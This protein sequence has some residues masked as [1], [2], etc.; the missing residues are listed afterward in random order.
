M[1]WVFRTLVILLCFQGE[2][3]ADTPWFSFAGGCWRRVDSIDVNRLNSNVKMEDVSFPRPLATND[4][5]GKSAAEVKKECLEARR[6]ALDYATD[7]AAKCCLPVEVAYGTGP[8][9]SQTDPEDGVDDAH[10]I[11]QWAKFAFTVDG[12]RSSSHFLCANLPKAQTPP[13][14]TRKFVKLTVVCYDGKI[15]CD[16]QSKFGR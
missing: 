9:P 4:L 7:W 11:M 10:P 15:R 2:A 5:T 6:Q 1:N 16:F 8:C 3:F 12:K 14:E 13:G